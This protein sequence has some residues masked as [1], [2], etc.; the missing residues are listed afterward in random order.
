MKLRL[1]LIAGFAAALSACATTSDPI[2][3]A[4]SGKSAGT[5]FAKF[6]PP[7]ADDGSGSVFAWK[8]GYKR[9][10]GD[11]KSCSASVS[12]TDD[13][14]IRSINVTGDRK[15]EHSVSYC[16]ELLAPDSV[17]PQE[18]VKVEPKKP[19]KVSKKKDD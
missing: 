10:G 12:V 9:V 18:T 11:M 14:N 3:A 8:G 4:W 5:F 19:A 15:G 17:K 13:Y 6:G 2:N 1:M 7:L 16:R